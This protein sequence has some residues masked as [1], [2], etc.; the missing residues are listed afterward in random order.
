MQNR[1]IVLLKGIFMEI[2]SIEKLQKQ[3]KNK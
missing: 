3:P 1:Q 2:I